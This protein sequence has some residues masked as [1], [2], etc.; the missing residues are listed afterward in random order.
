ME[1]R[2][3]FLAL[4]VVLA[5][6]GGGGGG[7]SSAP[8]AAPPVVQAPTGFNY[9]PV[10]SEDLAEV[11][12]TWAQRDLSAQGVTVAYQQA[13]AAY[14]VTIYSHRVGANTHVGA[15][16][17][18]TTA[19]AGSLPVLVVLDGLDQSNPSM[20]LGW[21]LAS[22]RSDAVLVV[23]AYRGRTLRHAGQSFVANG[24][25][26]DAYD[27]A[28][29]DAIAL[30]NVVAATTPSANM[31]RVVVQGYS[32]GGNVAL[33]MGMRDPRVRVV[34]AGAGPVDFYRA[35]PASRYGSQYTCQF[36]TGK[37]ESA[38]RIRMLASSPL[39]FRLQPGVTRVELFHGT[40]DEIVPLWNATE[41]AFALQAQG[42]N[43]RLT[44]YPGSTHSTIWNNPAFTRDWPQAQLDALR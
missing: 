3:L 39:H 20:D 34:L 24:D 18:P 14:Q 4:S 6:C 37:T 41:M 29:D 44:T 25:F 8:V 12:A 36:I 33:L 30:L 31:N 32:R 38:S 2:A 9:R 22:Y 35:E 40:A 10:T 5:A 21:P 11:Q 43:V 42:A 16:V 26:C 27:G 13:T 15:V 7:T 19:A 1:R 28:T 17:A 23:P